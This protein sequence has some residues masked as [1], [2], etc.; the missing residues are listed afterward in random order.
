MKCKI[1][2]DST[3]IVFEEEDYPLDAE[4]RMR[5]REVLDKGGIVVTCGRNGECKS[6]SRPAGEYKILK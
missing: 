4:R 1:K 6:V 2:G 5:D 3:V